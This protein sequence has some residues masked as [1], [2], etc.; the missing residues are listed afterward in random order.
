MKRALA[1]VVLVVAAVAALWWS[2]QPRGP[3]TVSGVIESHDIRVGS[4]VGG[5]VREVHVRE[6]DVVR[7]GDVLVTLEPYDLAERLAEARAMLAVHQAA[8]ARLKAGYRAEETAQARAARDRARAALEK[9]TAGPRPLEKQIARDRLALAEADLRKAQFDFGKVRE[10]HE[11]GESTTEE[12]TSVTRSLEAASA[13]VSEATNQLALLEEGTRAEEIAEARALLGEAE[14]A[15]A[16]REAGYRAEDI[17]EAEAQVRAAESRIAV[18]VRQMDE[19]AVRAPGACVVEAVDLMPGDLV[20][21]GAP[22]MTL[23]DTG[24]L[25]VRAYVP[26]SW[27]RLRPGDPLSVRVDGFPG[28]RFGGRVAYI[29]REAEFTPTNAQTPEE[30]SKRVFRVKVT[31]EEGRGELRPGMLADVVL[32]ER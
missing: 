8:L 16:L 27:S 10:L 24:D 21:A 13:R 20:A 2:Q 22:V 30:R 15:L 14:A 3:V 25:W 32:E 6:G 31:L 12:M 18:I 4:R 9:A 5:R 29:S 26:V 17:A 19:L 1:V 23:L 7:G 28:R 11:R